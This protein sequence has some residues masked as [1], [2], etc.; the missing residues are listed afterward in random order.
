M[1]ADQLRS[2]LSTPDGCRPHLVGWNVRDPSRGVQNLR[3]IADHL[4]PEALASLWPAFG[5]LLPR[6][7][8]QDMAL[9]NLERFF[10]S[11]GPSI[12]PALLETRAR[13]LEILLGLFATSQMFSDLLARHP[14]YFDMV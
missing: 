11:A 5:R 9:N 12:V 13:P 10:A 14:D 8:E 1:H 7:P 6:C 4:T 2:L 3:A